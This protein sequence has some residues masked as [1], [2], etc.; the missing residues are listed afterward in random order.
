MLSYHQEVRQPDNIKN[1]SRTLERIFEMSTAAKATIIMA[2]MVILGLI[3]AIII[4][5]MCNTNGKFR[6]DYDE[7]QQK[8]IGKGYKKAMITA[9]VMLGIYYILDMGGVVLPV[10]NSV[11]I[12]TVIFVLA[13]VYVLYA[14]WTDAYWGRNN[15][16]KSY[17]A[18]FTVITLFNLFLSV[19]AVVDGSMIVDG[20]LTTRFISVE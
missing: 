17:V 7:R 9:W 15:K 8:M 19:M 12:F 20:V 5:K 6:T 10:E 3:I 4:V 11:L 16:Y 13:M 18:A 2:S 1:K 14:V